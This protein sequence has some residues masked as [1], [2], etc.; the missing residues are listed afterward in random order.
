[1]TDPGQDNE[2]RTESRPDILKKMIELADYA[3]TAPSSQEMLSVA[4]EYLQACFAVNAMSFG[5]LQDHQEHV[6]WI[7]LIE[8]QTQLPAAREQVAKGFI[9]KAVLNR[10]VL[11][12]DDVDGHTQIKADVP[13]QHYDRSR[14]MMIAPVSIKGE[15]SGVLTVKSYGDY[16]YSE[17]DAELLGLVCALIGTGFYIFQKD[18]E[19]ERI[20]NQLHALSEN[21]SSG[22]A[23]IDEHYNLIHINK[24][25]QRELGELPE[26]STCFT[27][28]YNLQQPCDGCYL[29]QLKS[30]PF[31][32]RFVEITV[33]KKRFALQLIPLNLTDGKKVFLELIED[34]TELGLLKDHLKEIK[35]LNSII[36]FAR[37]IGHELNQPLTGISGYCALLKEEFDKESTAYQDIDEI[38]KQALR[39]ERIINKFQ[40]VTHLDY[41]EKK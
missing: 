39:L 8:G 19:T 1:M 31:P 22:I 23:L 33:D 16:S 38:E 12:I 13:E 14:S 34:R 2:V 24:W 28:L 7:F 17:Q 3:K 25:L 41:K 30:E 26:Q 5:W 40:S 37:S 32:D 9:Q 11:I 10:E 35:R 29:N 15:I 27:T 6:D 20:N 21:L 18:H 4:H 36:T